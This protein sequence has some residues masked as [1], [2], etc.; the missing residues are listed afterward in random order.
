[1]MYDV[2][3]A[4]YAEEDL[5]PHPAVLLC[6]GG[7]VAL[8][9][10][11]SLELPAAI[12]STL[13]GVLMIVGADVD[14]RTYLL[15]DTVTG[16]GTALGILAAPALA[17][18]EPW[19]NAGASAA[20]AAGVALALVL[21]RWAYRLLKGRDGVGLGDVKLAAAVGAWLPFACIPFCF[22]LATCSGL[23]AVMLARLRGE[24]VDAAA[25]VPFGAFLCPA[26][27]LVFY[28][29]ELSG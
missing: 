8:I 15:P 3:N 17:P 14:A 2:A 18:S 1:M 23:A 26:L 11:T 20:R 7:A 27:W 12:A 28:M 16:G 6:G 21:L 25:K 10:M 4:I 19:L 22:A 5:R 29:C 9:S 13:L 24:N